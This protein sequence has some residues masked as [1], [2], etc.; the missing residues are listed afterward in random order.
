MRLVDD[1]GR[2]WRWFST[3]AFTAIAAIPPAWAALPP[4]V[5]ELMPE[6]WGLWVFSAL[7]FAGW[8]GRMVDQK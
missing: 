8:V 1:A 7:A 5:K 2:A 6:D 4:D 3:W